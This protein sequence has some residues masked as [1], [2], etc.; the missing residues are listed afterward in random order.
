MGQDQIIE[1]Y[2]YM[3]AESILDS[4]SWQDKH[5]LNIFLGASLSAEEGPPPLTMPNWLPPGIQINASRPLTFPWTLE[6]D[7]SYLNIMGVKLL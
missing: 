5:L 4:I 1:S 6:C 7:A 3:V 2:L